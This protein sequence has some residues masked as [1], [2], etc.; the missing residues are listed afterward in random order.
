MRTAS[1]VCSCKGEAKYVGQMFQAS[2]RTHAC[3]KIPSTSNLPP[4]MSLRTDRTVATHRQC[5]PSVVTK[6]RK[7]MPDSAVVVRKYI[8]ILWSSLLH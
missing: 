8:L 5:S 7:F 2:H 3:T 6:C 1:H 4:K